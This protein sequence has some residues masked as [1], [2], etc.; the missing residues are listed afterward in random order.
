[1]SAMCTKQRQMRK[2][3]S[4][5]SEDAGNKLSADKAIVKIL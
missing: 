4:S 1:L 5:E 2:A 3:L